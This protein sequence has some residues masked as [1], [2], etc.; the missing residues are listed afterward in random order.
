MADEIA[1]VPVPE[2][3]VPLL[4]PEDIFGADDRRFLEIPI[5]EWRGKLRFGA[6][7]AGEMMDF[8][9]SNQGAAKKTSGLRLIIISMVDAAGNRIGKLNT[10]DQW[11]KKDTKVVNGIIDK[12]MSFN[13]MNID[14]KI[15]MALLRAEKNGSGEAATDASP[16]A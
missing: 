15:L 2:E 12:L 6:L 11:K 3:E 4:T 13:D 5:P 1:K 7:S 16:S 14:P 8:T 10:L 9:D